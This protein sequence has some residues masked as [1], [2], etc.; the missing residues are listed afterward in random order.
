M[1]STRHI[2][3]VDWTPTYHKSDIRSGIFI[4]RYYAWTTLNKMFDNVVPFRNK[5]GGINWKVL[6]KMFDGDAKIWVEY[7]CGGMAHFFVLLASFIR[8]KKPIILNVHDFIR[9]Q[10]DTGKPYSFLKGLR[11]Y[12]TERLLLKCAN[13]VILP[14]PGLL[15]WF[16]PKKSQRVTKNSDIFWKYAA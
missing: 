14:S 7:G 11:L 2:V 13:V 9:Q 1:S 5:R 15:D 4:R 10:K 12:I 3:F 6:I 16:T 8:P